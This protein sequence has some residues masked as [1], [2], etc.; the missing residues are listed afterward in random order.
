MASSVAPGNDTGLTAKSAKK[1][2][3]IVAVRFVLFQ[4]NQTEKWSE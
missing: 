2:K 3:T 1:K 4:T